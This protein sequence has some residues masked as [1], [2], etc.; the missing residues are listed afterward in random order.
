MFSQSLPEFGQHVPRVYQVG[1]EFPPEIGPMSVTCA[2]WSQPLFKRCPGL[3]SAPCWSKFGPEATTWV[4]MSTKSG[5]NRANVGA[6]SAGVAP[7]LTN[8]GQRR[9][10]QHDKHCS[11]PPAAA[12]RW[13][14]RND[15]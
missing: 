12:E 3:I 13:V 7:M 6:I 14:F 10:T 1:G 5:S 4:E 8:L 2:A 15:E 9:Q 11:R